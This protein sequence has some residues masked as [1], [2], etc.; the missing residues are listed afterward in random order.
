MMIWFSA[1]VAR[2]Q[3]QRLV[4]GPDMLLLAGI[5]LLIVAMFAGVFIFS[6]VIGL[7]LLR[8]RFRSLAPF[9]L[10][11]PTLGAAFAVVFA[12]PTAYILDRVH[13]NG[14]YF[15]LLLGFPIGAMF[16][17]CIGL[18]PALLVKRRMRTER[19]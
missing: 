1:K 11:L 6:V 18:V 14:A 9:V 12:W 4:I 15:R 10:F 3:S 17:L 16:G 5:P 19:N 2:W 8:S 7:V 13:P